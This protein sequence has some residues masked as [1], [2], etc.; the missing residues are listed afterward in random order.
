MKIETPNQFFGNLKIPSTWRYLGRNDIAAG[1]VWNSVG[2]IYQISAEKVM[3]V[4][5]LPALG[6][7]GVVEKDLKTEKYRCLVD[8]KTSEGVNIFLSEKYGV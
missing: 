3:R 6:V 7:G 5:F 8:N 1:G 2:F 4:C